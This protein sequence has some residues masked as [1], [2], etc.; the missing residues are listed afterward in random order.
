MGEPPWLSARTLFVN[1]NVRSFY[2]TIR[3]TSY[4]L[5]QRILDSQN[6]IVRSMLH[7]DGFVNSDLRRTWIN[8]LFTS[9]QNPAYI[10][11]V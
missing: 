2:E 7:S 9:S 8:N 3:V 11:W 6:S 10:V 1:L 5:M 4:G